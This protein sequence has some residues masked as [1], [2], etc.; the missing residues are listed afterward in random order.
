MTWLF[1]WSGAAT[2]LTYGLNYRSAC[3]LQLWI[4]KMISWCQIGMPVLLTLSL[5]CQ[6]ITWLNVLHMLLFQSFLYLNAFC[7]KYN[8][9]K[10][11]SVKDII[12]S[13]LCW[14]QLHSNSPIIS[15]TYKIQG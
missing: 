4:S 1:Y 10:K 7:T 2:A 8:C 3:A 5:M 6:H 15:Y 11:L 12:C 14:S 13:L 9:N